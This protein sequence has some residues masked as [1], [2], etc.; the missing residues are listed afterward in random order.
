M[1]VDRILFKSTV[2]IPDDPPT[3]PQYVRRG[4]TFVDSIKGFVHNLNSSTPTDPSHY[5]QHGGRTAYFDR[6]V[7][8]ASEKIRSWR[9]AGA[10]AQ[11]AEASPQHGLLGNFFSRGRRQGVASRSMDSLV[12]PER[13][14]VVGREAS[15]KLKRSKSLQASRRASLA[16]SIQTV[17]SHESGGRS[18]WRRRRSSVQGLGLSTSPSAVDVASTSN[19]PLPSSPLGASPIF[20]TPTLPLTSLPLSV[21]A[22]PDATVTKRTRKRPTFSVRSSS[23]SRHNMSRSNSLGAI[24]P[25]ALSPTTTAPPVLDSSAA[26]GDE[27]YNLSRPHSSHGLPRSLTRASLHRSASGPTPASGHGASLSLNRLKSFFHLPSLP[28][29]NDKLAEGDGNLI[30]SPGALEPPVSA[31]VVGPRKGEVQVLQYDAVVDLAKM[32]AVSDHRPV[33]A[34]VAVGVGGDPVNV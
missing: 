3:L 7:T 23:S 14:P 17:A 10:E 28:F 2:P 25:S 13:S 21:A 9:T 4:S 20:A 29:L 6:P 16:P 27:G 32:E 1:H 33:F 15:S 31:V 8:E 12:S 34:V 24:A 11:A 5:A 22:H 30:I 26:A 19:E 18:F